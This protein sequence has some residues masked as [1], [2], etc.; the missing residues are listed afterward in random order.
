MVFDA[1]SCA[2]IPGSDLSRIA[3]QVP[4]GTAEGVYP[5]PRAHS[6]ATHASDRPCKGPRT[7]WDRVSRLSPCRVCCGPLRAACA[8]GLQAHGGAVARL[9]LGDTFEHVL[10]RGRGLDTEPHGSEV[11]THSLPQRPQPPGLHCLGRVQHLQEGVPRS[12]IPA[13]LDD[14][15]PPSAEPL[16]HRVIHRPDLDTDYTNGSVC[17]RLG[18]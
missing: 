12:P 6:H 9:G 17:V 2:L 14:G 16:R 13:V 8:C 18:P 15:C 5:H 1:F 10:D 4:C 7:P 3:R 11:F